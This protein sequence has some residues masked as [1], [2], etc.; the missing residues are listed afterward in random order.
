MGTIRS[1]DSTQ[2]SGEGV[3]E[4]ID[5][6]FHAKDLLLCVKNIILLG[7]QVES[8]HDDSREAEKGG[9]QGQLKLRG[10]AL[11]Q[12]NTTPV[13]TRIYVLNN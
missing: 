7:V 13:T 6:D 2:W 12:T 9:E 3:E 5:T 11:S 8:S 1:L 4:S 10:E